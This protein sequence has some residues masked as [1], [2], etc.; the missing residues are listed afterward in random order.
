MQ[1]EFFDAIVMENAWELAG[2]GVRKYDLIRWNLL[3]EKID[4]FKTTYTNAVYNATYPKYVNF[5]YR[6]DNPMYIDMTS[7]VFGNKV[8][9]EYQNKAFFGA[10]TDDSS[11]KNLKVN[12]PSISSGLNNAVKNR[13][14]LPIASTTISTSNGK[15][16]NSYGYSD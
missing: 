1:K 12:L 5:K 9:G 16:H 6:T 8:G 3:S 2:E 11:Q 7:L 10:E 13:Y 15:L 14:L 4:E